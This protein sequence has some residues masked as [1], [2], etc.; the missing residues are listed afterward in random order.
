[1]FR[2]ITVRQQL[3]DARVIVMD[4]VVILIGSLWNWDN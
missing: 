1:M 4:W 3:I 2:V